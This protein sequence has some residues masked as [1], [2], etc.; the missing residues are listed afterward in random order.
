MNDQMIFD[1][2]QDNINGSQKNNDT[3]ANDASILVLEEAP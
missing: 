2:F 3:F 1:E